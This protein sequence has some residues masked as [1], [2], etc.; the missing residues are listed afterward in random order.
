MQIWF[1]QTQAW[2]VL[3]AQHSLSTKWCF[4]DLPFRC[5]V[6]ITFVDLW[7]T[8][9]FTGEKKTIQYDVLILSTICFSKVFGR[10]P[11][12]EKYLQINKNPK[13]NISKI[14]SSAPKN[15]DSQIDCFF[16]WNCRICFYLH[17]MCTL[18][19]NCSAQTESILLQHKLNLQELPL[20][21]DPSAL[22][23][24]R[25]VQWPVIYD[26]VVLQ[27]ISLEEALSLLEEHLLL[28]NAS[29]V[30]YYT[31]ELSH[32]IEPEMNLGK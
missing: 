6:V 15:V 10:P 20:R 16:C 29:T 22:R 21:L 1:Q 26:I 2:I 9:S 5:N 11:N 4:P 27:W 7:S 8:Y 31:V 17:L 19:W 3:A 25:P 14:A 32:T 13:C 24:L 28:Q 12:V 23:P 18:K 30:L